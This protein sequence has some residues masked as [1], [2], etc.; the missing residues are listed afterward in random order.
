[1]QLQRIMMAMLAA[2]SP[3]AAAAA[4][5][6]CAGPVTVC[7]RAAPGAVALLAPGRPTLIAVD[8][9][10]DAGVRRAADDL[11][12]DLVAVGGGAV[13][14]VGK[15]DAGTTVIAGTLGSPLVGALI[16]AGKIDVRGLDGQWEGYVEQVVERPLPGVDRALVIV[17]ADRRGTIFGLYDISA[18]AGVSPW[19]WWADVPAQR[20]PTLYLTA[21]RVADHPVVKYRGIFIN[22][23]EPAFGGWARARFGGVNHLAYEKLFTLLLRAKANFL[24]PAMWGKSLWQ[25]DP[26]SAPL[27]R[28]MGVILGTS[29]HEPMER[30]NIEWQRQ[31]GGPWDYTRN[32]ERLRAFWRAGIARRGVSEDPVTIG[33]RGDGDEP[34]T[35]GTA[36]GL[37]QRIIADQRRTI[38]E[39]T[40]KPAAATPQVWA[41]YKEV[42]DYY[43]QGMRVPDDVTL[44]FADDNWGNIRRLPV[45]GEQRAGGA[46][47]YYHFDYVGG[48]RNYKWLDTNAVPRVWQQMAMAHQFGADRLWIV[49][50]GD[51][52]PM[53]YATSFFLA[54]AW[55][56]D[57][58]TEAAM[59]AYPA[60]WAAQQ[61][62]A[63]QGPAIGALIVEYG[64]LASRR[65]PELIDADTYAGTA[66]GWARV[67]GEW[68]ALAARAGRLAA[69]IPTERRD[70]YDELVLHRIDAMT[71]LHRLYA[72]VAANRRAA[73]AGD[74]AATAR[75][76]T[77]AP[78][79]F[80][81]DAALRRRYEG[82]AGGKWPE[83]MAQTHIGYTGWQQPDVDVMP[84]LAT[85][86]APLP[87]P[88][89]A[90][91][92][93]RS[94]AAD[95][96][97]AIDGAGV[98]WQRVAG[99][100]AAGAAMI[101]TPAT[102]PAIERPG[103]A[104][105]QL[106]YAIDLPAG[107]RRFD[108]V[109][110]PGL[111]V[112][113]TGRHRVAL[114]LD[115]GAPVIVDLLAGETEARWG[116]AVADNRRVAGATLPVTR[117]GRHVLHVWLVDPQVVI[118]GI[119][120]AG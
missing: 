9:G 117:A 37:L 88:A 29:H 91:P 102:A 77:A 59:Q 12:D 116:K 98:R 119:E 52:K 97:R 40:G 63:A 53:E 5:P 24:W 73:Q 17:G 112:R 74:A 65:K 57:R 96:G 93:L 42:Q 105:P 101:A 26:A 92:P 25:D 21:G 58:M 2:A 10:E 46:G 4:I 23:E 75:W 114:S 111:D 18:K 69:A 103:G 86:A 11:V 80:A 43:D 48:P 84:A 61:F 15:A 82:L 1:M 79:Y 72:A 113:G 78:G 89:M 45:P 32:A 94:I 108:V 104:G 30:A 70:A 38:A 16:R 34:M 41:L 7:M 14:L 81:E 3:A 35:Q 47:V 118:E 27:A 90:T 55:D 67:L 66:G 68:T 54:M 76:A 36:I 95:A 22:D 64:R 19:T 120:V 107:A 110:A 6:D 20:H 62:G 49:N 39:V 33:M 85:V 100:T 28:E 106:A 109:A 71:N 60:R 50:V 56:P 83:M 87:V 51:L 99:F 44:L 31:G 115:G 13:R 8:A